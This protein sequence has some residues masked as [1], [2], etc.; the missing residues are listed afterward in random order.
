MGLSE[1]KAKQIAENEPAEKTE[2]NYMNQRELSDYERKGVEY[3]KAYLTDTNQNQ[4]I[5]YFKY[6]TDKMLATVSTTILL[7]YTFF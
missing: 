3:V 2:T 7:T 5:Q 6:Y 4:F 1:L